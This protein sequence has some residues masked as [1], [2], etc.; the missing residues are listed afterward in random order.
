MMSFDEHAEKGEFSMS[1]PNMSALIGLASAS[2]IYRR[3]V[4]ESWAHTF[5]ALEC[6][7]PATLRILEKS[8]QARIL[9]NVR[10]VLCT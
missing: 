7:D 2:K 6:K 4:L 1:R 10:L 3:M 8:N 9:C 5:L